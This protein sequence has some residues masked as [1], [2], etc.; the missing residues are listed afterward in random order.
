MRRAS[1]GPVDHE[2]GV[3]QHLEVLRDGGTADR[4][5]AGELADRPWPLGEM[6]ED[7]A[8]RRIGKRSETADLVSHDLR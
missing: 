8:P 5:L 7:Q 3:L 4:Q 2:P 1:R 6:L